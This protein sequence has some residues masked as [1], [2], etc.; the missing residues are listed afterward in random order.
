MAVS[1]DNCRSWSCPVTIYEDTGI[2][3]TTWF[4]QKSM[5][6]AYFSN[7]DSALKTGASYGLTVSVYDTKMP[8]WTRQTIEPYLLPTVGSPTGW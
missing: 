7:L 5:F 2:Y 3:P 6:V 4:S 8:L 1:R